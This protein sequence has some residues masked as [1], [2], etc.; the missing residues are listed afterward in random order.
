[1]NIRYAKEDEID[2]IKDIWN[3]CFN[4]VDSFVDYY[5]NHK[6]SNQNTIVACEDSDIV[7]S[8]QLNQYKI[9]LDNKIYDT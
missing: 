9:K 2:N 7:S 4:D 1:M 5:F 6:Y 3:Y 8:L